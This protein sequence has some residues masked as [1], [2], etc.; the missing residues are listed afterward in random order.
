MRVYL[1]AFCLNEDL[2]VDGWPEA[3]FGPFDWVGMTWNFLRA[4]YK[5][6]PSPPADHQFRIDDDGWVPRGGLPSGLYSDIEI[7]TEHE[8]RTSKHLKSLPKYRTVYD[9]KPQ[10]LKHCY[11]FPEVVIH[12]ED[13]SCGRYRKGGICRPLPTPVEPY[14]EDEAEAV[15][16]YEE[17]MKLLRGEPHSLGYVEWTQAEGSTIYPPEGEHHD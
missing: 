1:H 3:I 13:N 2:Y 17:A 15:S 14:T 16:R 7:V 9:V 8:L 12:Q 6:E 10:E 11:D 4:S 5:D